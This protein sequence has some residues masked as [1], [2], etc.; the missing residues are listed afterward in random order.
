MQINQVQVVQSHAK[1]PW[2]NYTLWK[3]FYALD[4]QMWYWRLPHGWHYYKLFSSFMG[5][6]VYIGV[7]RRWTCCCIKSHKNSWSSVKSQFPQNAPLSWLAQKCG[8]PFIKGVL[9]PSWIIPASFW[10]QVQRVPVTPGV[11]SEH[12]RLQGTHSSQKCS[13]KCT[14]KSKCYKKILDGKRKVSEYLRRWR[15]SENGR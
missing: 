5:G 7:C 10:L 15:Q 2:E 3:I 1:E 12:R 14:E 4:K 9:I 8:K 6:R 11:A 13:E